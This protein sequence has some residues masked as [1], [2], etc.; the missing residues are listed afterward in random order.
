MALDR[1]SC[2]VSFYCARRHKRRRVTYD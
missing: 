2:V 1:E